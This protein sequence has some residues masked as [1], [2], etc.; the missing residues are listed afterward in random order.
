MPRTVPFLGAA[1]A[2]LLAGSA[3]RFAFGAGVVDAQGQRTASYNST[4]SDDDLMIILAV[5]LFALVALSQA[6]LARARRP[7]AAIVAFTVAWFFQAWCLHWIEAASL[8][9]SVRLADG[10]AL[11]AF[12]LLFVASLPS[13][14]LAFFV[15]RHP[16]S[17]QPN[18]PLHNP[19]MQPTGSARS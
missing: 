4:G 5:P 2:V 13:L 15:S 3:L 18:E 14:W 17:S 1:F 12:L 11:R 10:L 8:T 16:A 19:A 9:T 7:L 6:I